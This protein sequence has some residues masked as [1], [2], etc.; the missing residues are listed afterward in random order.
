MDAL[1]HET[2]AE[3][4]ANVLFLSFWV[5]IPGVPREKGY[6]RNDEIRG[7]QNYKNDDFI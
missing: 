7:R 5:R 6:V 3:L 1:I 4:R 2:M